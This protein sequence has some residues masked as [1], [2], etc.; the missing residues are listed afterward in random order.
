MQVG[1]TPEKNIKIGL[2]LSQTQFGFVTGTAFTFTNGLMG[3]VWG[4]MSDKYNR[5]WPLTV[6]CFLMTACAV[7]IS[8][9]DN[10]WQVLVARIGF[11]IF[12]SANVPVSVSL[13][14]DYAQPD[15]RGRA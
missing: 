3:L 4:H 12:M 10:Y 2:N 11:A 13:I 5:K 8:F 9:C 14:C 7:S 1:T 15:E 6:C